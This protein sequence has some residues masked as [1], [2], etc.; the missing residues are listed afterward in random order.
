MPSTP[1]TLTIR[2]IANDGK[3]L[4]DDIGG[5]QITVRDADTQEI[6]AQGFT[7][8]G[9]GPNGTNGDAGVMCVALRRGQPIPNTG[10]SFYNAVL[11]LDRPRR[12]QVTAFGPLGCRESANTVTATTWVYP[13]R[14]MMQGNGFLLELPGLIVQIVN[15]PTHTVAIAPTGTVI[16][17]NVAMMCGC[18]I[19]L[20]PAG[21]A[22]ICDNLSPAQQ[23]WQ[24]SEFEVVATIV[25]KPGN[26]VTTLPMTFDTTTNVAG[27]FFA[28]WPNVPIGTYQI[29][30]HAY[31]ASTGNTG[32]AMSTYIVSAPTT[33]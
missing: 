31:Q 33:T 6:L 32:V 30:V 3:F 21:P 7:S 26:T 22:T 4:G 19:D 9:S 29:T 28:R 20:K 13:G 10:A 5:A 17:A 16:T 23:P 27:Q 18:P 11:E 12:V 15:P 2:V 8:G 25:D 1:T 14:N 24:P